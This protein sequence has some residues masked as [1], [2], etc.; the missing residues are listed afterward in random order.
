MIKIFIIISIIMT[1]ITIVYIRNCIIKNK[2]FNKIIGSRMHPLNKLTKKKYRKGIRNVDFFLRCKFRSYGD[3]Y[4]Q[5][6]ILFN[7]ENNEELF[8]EFSIYDDY[9]L[10]DFIAWGI[11]EHV[12]CIHHYR[13]STTIT[14]LELHSDY[15]RSAFKWDASKDYSDYSDTIRKWV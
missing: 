8:E 3:D 7:F 4:S 6:K 5:M 9:I 10:G 2:E 15:P 13:G 11:L 12:Y 1:V 14:T